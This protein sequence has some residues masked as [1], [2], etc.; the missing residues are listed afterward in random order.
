MTDWK[1][2]DGPNPGV[3]IALLREKTSLSNGGSAAVAIMSVVA[4]LML[5]GFVADNSAIRQAAYGAIGTGLM[6]LFG[7]CALIGRRRVYIVYRQPTDD[8]TK[9]P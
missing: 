5:F 3:R 8:P 4:A 7:V 1:D 6:V 2:F 9:K